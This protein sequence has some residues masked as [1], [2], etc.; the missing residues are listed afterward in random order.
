MRRILSTGPTRY[1]AGSADAKGKDIRVDHTE[2]QE[3]RG[4]QPNDG[5]A[6]M[7]GADNL[8][9]F[10]TLQGHRLLR[11]SSGWWVNL[12]PFSFLH[13]PFHKM[14][15]PHPSELQKVFWLGPAL[16]LRYQTTGGEVGRAGGIFLCS[17]KGY[18]LH[19]LESKARNQT[20]RGLEKCRV[21]RIE[22]QA[23]AESGLALLV[24]THQ[25]QGRSVP[26]GVK[27]KWN[28]LCAA[29]AATPGLEAWGSFVENRLAAF[30]VG[31]YVEDCF[32]ILHQGSD[33]T[34]LSSY[35]NNALLFTVT[36]V[37]LSESAVNSI[38]YG[39]KSL[40]PTPGLDKFK[41]QMGYELLARGEVIEIHPILRLGLTLGG[42]SLLRMLARRY[43]GND[44]WRKAQS[45]FA[46]I[47]PNS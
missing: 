22:F 9:H 24:D 21:G 43:P 5:A 7:A 46:P 12:Q 31:A 4:T 11:T 3:R 47:Y 10:Y 26:S 19:S 44:I 37:K 39:L 45:V 33:S 6:L 13:L 27:K 16:L 34:F 28:Q 36:Q 42:K 41:V 32:Y 40:D 30:I 15:E 14:V 17:E 38:N 29:G 35:P 25:R 8:A 18:G 2:G 20:R 1:S 23:L